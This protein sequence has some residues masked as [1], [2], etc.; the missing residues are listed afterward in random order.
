MKKF[1]RFIEDNTSI[2]IFLG[3]PIGLIFKELAFFKPYLTIFLML[4]LFFTFL[5]I[6][7]KDALTHI[8]RWQLILFIVFLHLILMPLLVFSIFKLINAQVFLIA[9][10]LMLASVPA[11][12]ASTAMTD[13]LNGDTLLSTVITIITHFVSPITIPFLFFILLRKVI[14]M[15]YLDTGITLIKLIFIPLVL[16][17]VFKVLLPKITKSLITYNKFFTT[18]IIS[19][20][21]AVI[22][23]INRKF[24]IEH[25]QDAIIY[26]LIAIPVYLSFITIP[27][28]LTPNLNLK[29]RISIFTTKTF[30][31]I[32]IGVVLAVSF[33]D[34]KTSLVLTLAQIPWSFMLFPSQ[35]IVKLIN[36]KPPHNVGDKINL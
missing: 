24:I 32:T 7:I 25:P 23:A 1:V 8:K 11:G 30:M 18:S 31:N 35:L 34:A 10:M 19:A 4:V 5:K 17:N 36:K 27:L 22:V 33:L 26:I 13:L 9:S 15:N 6:D 28:L 16:A 12:V 14:H 3:I 29:E 21:G 20:L 2:I